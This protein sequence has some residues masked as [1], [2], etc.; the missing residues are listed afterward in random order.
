MV[1][2]NFFVLYY[3]WWTKEY[4]SILN[5]LYLEQKVALWFNEDKISIF[6]M[7]FVLQ[8]VELRF[9]DII[10]GMS[11]NIEEYNCDT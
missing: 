5:N 11:H 1:L 3:F 7:S 4:F 8:F 2:N 6:V 9:N 10:E